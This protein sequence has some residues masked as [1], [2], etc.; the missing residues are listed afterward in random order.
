[1]TASLCCS[2]SAAA[3]CRS[4]APPSN[5]APMK[6]CRA[7]A[8]ASS[9]SRATATA[10]AAPD[11]WPHNSTPDSPCR[12]ISPT[13]CSAS[14]ERGAKGSAPVATGSCP[15][16]STAYTTGPPPG[17]DRA[18]GWKL[19]AFPPACGKHTR[20]PARPSADRDSVWS[21][22]LPSV[23]AAGAPPGR[24]SPSGGS[25]PAG[26]RPERSSTSAARSTS[27]GQRVTSFRETV[28]SRA[29]A[30]RTAASEVPPRS[31][32]WSSRPTRSRGTPSTWA[33][34]AASRCSVGVAGAAYPSPVPPASVRSA[35]SA[36]SAV[37][38][39]RSILPLAVSGRLSRQ[40]KAGGTM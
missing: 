39:F 12:P 38:A 6:R 1:M 20:A 10:S 32:K 31:K 19:T 8:P 21:N 13:T 7:G 25:T 16:N 33:Q 23:P 17:N 34:A 35:S 11:E 14:A 9:S 24:L 28:R 15:G 2:N 37:N 36:A 30:S 29:I 18:S 27:T 3:D 40:W 26:V 5:W 22:T 4:A